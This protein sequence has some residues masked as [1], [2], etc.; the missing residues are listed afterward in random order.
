MRDYL[1]VVVFSAA[2]GA[3]Y[4][5][6]DLFL[7][8][9][10]CIDKREDFDLN[11]IGSALIA[12]RMHTGSFPTTEQGL[13]ALVEQPTLPPF[14]KRWKAMADEVPRDPWGQEYRYRL[15][16]EDDPNRF[17]IWSPGKDRVDG[18]EDDL[19]SLV[20]R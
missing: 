16:P 1:A 14:P 10:G 17:E 3:T 13:K 5:F 18:T 20:P 9:G 11:S 15:F 2:V 12:Y 4:C 7:P 8:S 6:R 19:S